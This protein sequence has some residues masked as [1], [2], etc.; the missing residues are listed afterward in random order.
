MRTPR[1]PEH[2]GEEAV[3]TTRVTDAHFVKPD[4]PG[5][6]GR[7]TGVGCDR[8]RAAQFHVSVVALSL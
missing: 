6:R 7:L 5:D 8:A 3:A 2:E 4:G 1:R